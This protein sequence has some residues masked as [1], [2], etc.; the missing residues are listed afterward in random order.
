MGIPSMRIHISEKR[1]NMSYAVEVHS[2]DDDSWAGN[3]L[4]FETKEEADSYGFDLLSRWFTPDD[5][6]IVESEDPVNS[7]WV[8][9]VGQLLRLDT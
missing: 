3:A 9:T 4:R 2:P 5:Y 7:A 6:R 1:G 8:F